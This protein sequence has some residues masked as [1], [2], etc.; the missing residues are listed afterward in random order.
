M[1]FKKCLLSFSPVGA[2]LPVY[3]DLGN[4]VCYT[5]CTEGTSTIKPVNVSNFIK[6]WFFSLRIDGWAQRLWASE[7]LGQ[8]NLNPVL[9]NRRNILIPIKVREAVG[10]NDG[11]YGYVSL[12]QIEA[13]EDQSI[14]LKSG[15]RVPFLSSVR[16]V[17][18]KVTHA[19]LL[20]YSYDEERR[21]ND[22]PDKD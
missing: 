3:D 17:R 9:I 10:E 7:I 4:N 15:V 11:C 14:L 1:S 18:N 22:D 16:T 13:V 8:R 6:R 19:T 21:N 12:S 2:I 5:V 20:K